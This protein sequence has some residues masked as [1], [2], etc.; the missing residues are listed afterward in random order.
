MNCHRCWEA[1]AETSMWVGT[2]MK[3]VCAD[4]LEALRREAAERRASRIE[5]SRLVESGD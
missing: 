2:A 3:P 4:C 5:A 1:E